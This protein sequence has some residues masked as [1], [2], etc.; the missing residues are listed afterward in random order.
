MVSSESSNKEAYQTANP[1]AKEVEKVAMDEKMRRTWKAISGWWDGSAKND[2]RSGCGIVIKGADTGG[3]V[4]ISEIAVP[5]EKERSALVT[6]IVGVNILTEVFDLIATES[7]TVTNVERCI[8]DCRRV[9]MC[10]IRS[11]CC[12]CDVHPWL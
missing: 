1:G 5:F 3:W 10:M 4:T 11:K 9:E 7:V 8:Y 2:G 12:R 6:A